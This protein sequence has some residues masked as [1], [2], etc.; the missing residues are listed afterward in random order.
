MQF[1]GYVKNLDF[2]REKYAQFVALKLYQEMVS[3]MVN[4]DIYTNLVRKLLLTSLILQPIQSKKT[5]DKWLKYA[6][7][8]GNGYCSK[9]CSTFVY[10]NKRLKK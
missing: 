10:Q 7:C 1:L 5:L 2:L 6:K 3:I 8:M 9:Q 4:K